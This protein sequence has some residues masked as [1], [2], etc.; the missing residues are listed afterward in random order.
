MEA[1]QEALQILT[2]G[3]NWKAT[4]FTTLRD[5]EARQSSAS[6]HCI[7]A[8]AETWDQ[9]TRRCNQLVALPRNYPCQ[10]QGWRGKLEVTR[11]RVFDTKKEKVNLGSPVQRQAL[12]LCASQKRQPP[13]CREP[14][15][16][17][18]QE[19][20]TLKLW[21]TSPDAFFLFPSVLDSIP[22]TGATQIQVV[23][24][25]L[26]KKRKGNKNKNKNLWDPE[27]VLCPHLPLLSLNII[28]VLLEEF[29]IIHISH[30]FPSPFISTFY[31]VSS[32]KY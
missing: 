27:Q 12:G 23:F 18:L 2:W 9:I 8:G 20:L 14:N 16:S 30:L 24:S 15:S 21:A 5:T 28:F 7:R 22:W 3:N 10:P 25:Y 4:A 17:A 29:H 6:C 31:P 13:P 26:K 1:P 32:P 11:T 19:Q